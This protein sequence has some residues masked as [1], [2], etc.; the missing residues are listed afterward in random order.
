MKQR[1]S[2]LIMLVLL[3]LGTFGCA[4]SKMSLTNYRY[5]KYDGPVKI[6]E[7]PPDTID[8]IEIGFLSSSSSSLSQSI[9]AMQSEASKYGSN[10]IVITGSDRSIHAFFASSNIGTYGGLRGQSDVSAVAIRIMG[11]HDPVDPSFEFIE[12]GNK[13]ASLGTRMNVDLW[14]IYTVYSLTLLGDA[15]IGND[16]FAGSFIPVVGPFTTISQIDDYEGSETDKSLMLASGVVQSLF[17]ADLCITYLRR[18]SAERRFQMMVHPGYSNGSF[19]TN[20]AVSVR[21]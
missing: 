12:T 11:P 18:E 17:F 3:S 21:F 16:L 9:S 8:Y 7:S 19:S 15:A 6:L 14:G 20:L 5:P 10:A 13:I 2:L 1:L 4:T